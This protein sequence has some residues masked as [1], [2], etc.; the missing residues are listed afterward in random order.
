MPILD[1]TVQAP[2][3]SLSSST[4]SQIPYCKFIAESKVW[5]GC[6]FIA[7]L[8]KYYARCSYLC[9]WTVFFILLELAWHCLL[10]SC[11]P[12]WQR[13][14]VNRVRLSFVQGLAE[15]ATERTMKIRQY[16]FYFKAPKHMGT[17]SGFPMTPFLE[18]AL[19]KLGQGLLT[20]PISPPRP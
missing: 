10:S 12:H 7:L 3:L 5:D 15:E 11:S 20:P 13:V 4:K 19:V 2:K 6:G 9:A 16:V 8:N 18:H 14:L 17:G 1:F